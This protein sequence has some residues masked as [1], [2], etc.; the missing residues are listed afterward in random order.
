ML[1]V[2]IEGHMLTRVEKTS[3]LRDKPSDLSI[4]SKAS[5]FSDT[6]SIAYRW[7]ISIK[8]NADQ[9]CSDGDVITNKKNPPLLSSAT[10]HAHLQHI[11]RIV[12]I[13]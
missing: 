8:H 10:L 3:F 13:L 6:C 4:P 9:C 7:I 12:G 1:F 11:Q 5:H 2:V